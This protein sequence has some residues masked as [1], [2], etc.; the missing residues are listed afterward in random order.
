MDFY[1]RKGTTKDMASVHK[2][3][4]E[5]AVFENEPDA[6]KISVNDLMEDGFGDDPQFEVFVA[7][8]EHIIVGMAL[9]YK[10]YSTW[11]GRSLHL[12]DLIVSN[13]YRGRGVGKALYTK[14]MEYADNNNINR[15]EWE[16][17]NWN[18]GAIE[19]YL[20]SG[21]TMLEDWNLCQMNRTD[22]KNFLKQHAGI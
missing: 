20:S 19:F 10:R 15:V 6:V 21:A 7:E 16:V 18:K 12:E 3:I 13:D 14:I 2:L 8:V 5:L 4:C 17:L 9:Y 11:E 22:V 1:I